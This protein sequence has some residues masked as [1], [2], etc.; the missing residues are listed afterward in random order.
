[1]LFRCHSTAKTTATTSSNHNYNVVSI[2][3][4]GNSIQCFYDFPQFLETIGQGRII[5]NA[6]YM[7]GHRFHPIN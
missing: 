2:A 6:C 3:H 5:Q 4:I 7:A 1:M